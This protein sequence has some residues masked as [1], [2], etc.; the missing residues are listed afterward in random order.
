MGERDITKRK[1]KNNFKGIE[2]V[3]SVHAPGSKRNV[4]TEKVHGYGISGP[5]GTDGNISAHSSLTF[6]EFFNPL[7]VLICIPSYSYYYCLKFRN[8][9][10]KVGETNDIISRKCFFIIWG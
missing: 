2:S 8:S 4:K 10:S 7:Y 6:S 5:F 3:N 9:V 1:K